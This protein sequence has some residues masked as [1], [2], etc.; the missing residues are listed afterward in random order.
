MEVKQI[1]SKWDQELRRLGNDPKTC[2]S[3]K[4][5][6]H[7]CKIFYN[8]IF[9]HNAK[10]SSMYFLESHIKSLEEA[11]SSYH[12]VLEENRS[13]YNQVQDLKGTLES[14]MLCQGST[15]IIY[16]F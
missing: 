13:L 11:S 6:L 12:K 8:A 16:V 1:Q 9:F 14:E 15:Y 2:F 7:V 10:L 5:I 4:N 3:M